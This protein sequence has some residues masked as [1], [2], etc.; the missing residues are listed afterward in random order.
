MLIQRAEQEDLLQILALQY[1]AYQ[2]EAKLLNDYTIQPLTQTPEAVEIEYASGIILKAVDTEGLII[3]SVRC[4]TAGDTCCIGKLIVHPEYQGQGIGTRLL[5][6]IEKA[7]PRTRYELF[8]SS[9]SL[10][11]IRLYER[12]GYAQ[13]QEKPLSPGLAMIYM[14]KRL[15]SC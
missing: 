13:Y 6:E 15:P 4:R 10:K 8:T 7:C 9:K 12:A 2:S 11:N 14:E 1:L 3:G 5:L